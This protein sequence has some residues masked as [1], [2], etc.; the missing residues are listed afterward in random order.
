M[1]HLSNTAIPTHTYTHLYIPILK[2]TYTHCV[3]QTYTPS[4]RNIDHFSL[5]RDN[6]ISKFT[7]L[8]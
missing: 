4:D 1:Q 5:S 3:L 6:Q 8:T 2:Y 7:I